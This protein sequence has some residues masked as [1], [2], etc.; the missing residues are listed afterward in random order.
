MLNLFGEPITTRYDYA[1]QLAEILKKS[2]RYQPIPHHTE[3][4]IQVEFLDSSYNLVDLNG[5][6]PG[7]YGFF[8]NEDDRSFYV[9]QGVI[10]TKRVYRFCKEALKKS[11]HDE[12]HPAAKIFRYEGFNMLDTYVTFIHEEDFP[13]VVNLS[14]GYKN[15]DKVVATVLKSKFNKRKGTY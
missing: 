6:K 3:N 1:K 11:R 4:G 7:L 2:D 15:I 14:G 12:G 8:S 5:N 13:P 10:V 9:G